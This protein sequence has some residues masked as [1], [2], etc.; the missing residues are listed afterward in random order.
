MIQQRP[1]ET[2]DSDSDQSLDL[3]SMRS[4]VFT[5]K[6]TPKEKKNESAAPPEVINC[7]LRI[8]TTMK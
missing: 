2:P 6:P 5:P 7:N 1:D 4:E 3:P 8:D